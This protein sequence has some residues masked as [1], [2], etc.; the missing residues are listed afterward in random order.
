MNR[1]SALLVSVLISL[2]A[3]CYQNVRAPGPTTGVTVFELDSNDYRV[4]GPVETEGTIV[5]ILGLINY[6]G[7]GFSELK[8]KA[9]ETGGDD[10]INVQTD[11]E[12]FSVLFVYNEFRWKATGTAIRYRSGITAAE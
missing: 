12:V 7:Q 5:S 1:V 11:L 8:K 2:T 9:V 10:V 4:L 6:G 3:G